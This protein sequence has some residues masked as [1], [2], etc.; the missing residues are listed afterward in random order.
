M[1]WQDLRVGFRNEYRGHV[2][3]VDLVPI[4]TGIEDG[5]ERGTLTD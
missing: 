5:G 2:V 3:G 4:G 1:D